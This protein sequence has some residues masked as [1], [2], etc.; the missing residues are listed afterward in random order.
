MEPEPIE[1][2]AFYAHD[3]WSRWMK[4]M[5]RQCRRLPG[6]GI[7]IPP[8]LVKRWERQMYKDYNELPESEKE[9]DVKEA[10]LIM[11]II[12]EFRKDYV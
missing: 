5:F 4:H 3:M 8:V 7:L 11:E 9:S 6:G 12:N 1:E 2:L 10:L